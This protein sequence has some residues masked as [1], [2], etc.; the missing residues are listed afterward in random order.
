M[1][2]L[3]PDI[4]KLSP[5]AYTV[6][7]ELERY[8]MSVLKVSKQGCVFVL[9]CCHRACTSLYQAPA[10]SIKNM[11]SCVFTWSILVSLS[12]KGEVGRHETRR[13]CRRLLASQPSERSMGLR[14]LA[15]YF[16]SNKSI[17]TTATLYCSC[18]YKIALRARAEPCA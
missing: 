4:L 13:V 11:P 9:W 8:K 1:Y 10:C 3:G 16:S 12:F 5:S 15:S 17:T 7:Q 6:A 18:V 14:S 2:M